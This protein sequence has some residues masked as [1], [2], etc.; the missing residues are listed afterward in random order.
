MINEQFTAVPIGGGPPQLRVHVTCGGA[1]VPVVLVFGTI[2]SLALFI[3][4]LA[5]GG[6]L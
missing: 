5:N 2:Y 3:V 1:L 6:K 4:D